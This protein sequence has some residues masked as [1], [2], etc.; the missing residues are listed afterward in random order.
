MVYEDGQPK[1]NDL[2]TKKQPFGSKEM[3]IEAAKHDCD[4]CFYFHTHLLR[5]YTKEKILHNAHYVSHNTA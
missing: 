3:A 1:T 5:L 2:L 4:L